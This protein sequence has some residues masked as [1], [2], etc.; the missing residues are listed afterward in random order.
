MATQLLRSHDPEAD[1]LGHNWIQRFKA[2]HHDRIQGAW[3][4]SLTTQRADALNPNA[5]AQYFDDV[6]HV[7]ETYDVKAKN[8]Y[9]ADET[10]MWE[11][12]WGPEWVNC[13]KGTKRQHVRQGGS[14][15]L[16]SVMATICG[17]G[18]SLPP[19]VIFKGEQ[20]Q[21]SWGENNPSN[22]VIARSS[23]GWTDTTLHLEYLKW[24]DANTVEKAEWGMETRTLHMDGHKTHVALGCAEYAKEHNIQLVGCPGQGTHAL[25]GLDRVHFARVKTLWPQ[26]VRRFEA[27]NGM[28][29]G[30]ENFLLVLSRVW[31]QV[32]NRE[33]N[34][35]AFEV[36]GLTRPVRPDV[37]T[38]EMMAPSIESSAVPPA[39][40]SGLPQSTPV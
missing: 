32:F 2:R 22:A 37:I 28:P 24:M 36:T 26:E 23:N 39:S 16:T 14:R 11:A 19:F 12:I 13:R 40:F 27:E 18:T 7:Y 38:P 15:D 30:R 3:G 1:N 31:S 5:V 29:V 17:D 4:S 21:S 34:I 10:S 20:F 25:Q 9:A 8:K 33:N 6:D 35:K